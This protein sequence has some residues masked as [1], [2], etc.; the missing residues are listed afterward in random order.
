[1]MKTPDEAALDAAKWFAQLEP[2]AV[3]LDRHVKPKIV[4]PRQDTIAGLFIRAT[5]LLA[6]LRKLDAATDFQTTMSITRALLEIAIDVTT[7]LGD[8]AAAQRVIDWEDS[9]RLAYAQRAVRAG[10]VF[11]GGA[12]T[13]GVMQAYVDANAARVEK[14]RRANGW[15]KKEKGSRALP[16]PYHPPRW[17]KN[18]LGKDAEEAERRVP[19]DLRAYRKMP[20][21]GCYERIYPFLCWATHGSSLALIRHTRVEM[22]HMFATLS[23]AICQEYGLYIGLVLLK[24]VDAFDPKDQHLHEL[25]TVRARMLLLD[26]ASRVA[27]DPELL[28]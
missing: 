12:A 24:H 9:A 5:Q 16:R 26:E 10:P 4:E 27:L 28:K 11:P 18:E 3:F 23:Y 17:T 19:T 7:I 13:S 8:P 14:F 25:M 21:T 1:M 22:V 6:T 15:T 20:F 2:I